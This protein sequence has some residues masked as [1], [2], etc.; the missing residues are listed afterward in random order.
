MVAA[1]V[2]GAGGST[3]FGGPK[4]QLLVPRVV[5]RVR[6]AE[7]VEDVIVV[8]GAY[9]VETDARVVPC[10]DWQLGPGA[11]LRCGLAALG[12]DVQAAVVVLADGPNLDPR[13]I[14]RVVEAWGTTGEARLAATYNGV[15]LHPVLLS[16][17]VWGQAPDEGL[18]DLPAMGVDCSDLDPPGDVDFADDIDG[19]WPPQSAE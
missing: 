9:D 8:T 17:H 19:G 16:R 15:R 6:A 2:L 7:T 11:S 14:D 1:V 3:R 5:E 12:P 13:A 4:Q 18:R 10:P